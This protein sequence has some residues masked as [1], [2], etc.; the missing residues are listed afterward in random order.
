MIRADAVRSAMLADSPYVALDSLIRTA[1]TNGCRVAEVYDQ[2]YA[3]LDQIESWPEYGGDAAEAIDRALDALG[4]HC[5]P[6]W[7]YT[8]AVTP[9]NGTAAN[10]RHQPDNTRVHNR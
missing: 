1:L 2:L 8:D 7:R 10:G 6:N 3:L 9:T 5:H 4:G